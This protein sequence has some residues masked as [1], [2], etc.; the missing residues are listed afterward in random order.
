MAGTGVAVGVAC[1]AVGEITSEGS[2][3]GVVTAVPGLPTDGDGA[4]EGTPMEGG[5]VGVAVES[6][7]GKELQATQS[8]TDTG[9]PR[10][11]R[12]K[13]RRL[14]RARAMSLMITR[15]THPTFL[16]TLTLPIP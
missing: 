3:V 5:K 16:M 8:A 15:P 12:S 6:G 10:T 7:L 4:G 14:P 13:K 11:N 9:T 1:G 2:K